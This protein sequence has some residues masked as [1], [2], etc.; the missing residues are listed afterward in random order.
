MSRVEEKGKEQR[1]KLVSIAEASFLGVISTFR[2]MGFTDAQIA[3]LFQ[4]QKEKGVDA[5]KKEDTPD[6][7]PV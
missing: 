1:T 4:R 6:V 2:D 5:S 7:K 3:E